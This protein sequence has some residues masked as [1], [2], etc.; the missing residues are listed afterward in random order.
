SRGRSMARGAACWAGGIRVG[1][2]QPL[3]ELEAWSRAAGG[4]VSLR[5]DV[6]LG[7]PNPRARARRA[8][9][10]PARRE[11]CRTP[12]GTHLHAT[13]RPGP[14]DQLS[15]HAPGRKEDL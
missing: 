11:R 2:R 12:T 8:A 5:T 10:A 9:L 7:G 6:F 4:G 1:Q 13:R 15:A 14:A 3:E